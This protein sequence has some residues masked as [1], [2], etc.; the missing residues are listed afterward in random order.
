MNSL[1]A[2]I[3]TSASSTRLLTENPEKYIDRL[4]L[5]QFVFYRIAVIG[6][7]ISVGYNLKKK[8]WKS[9]IVHVVCYVLD[10]CYIVERNQT[11]CYIDGIVQMYCFIK[12]NYYLQFVKRFL[13]S[14]YRPQSR[15]QPHTSGI[16]PKNHRGHKIYLKQ[17]YTLHA[18]FLQIISETWSVCHMLKRTFRPIVKRKCNH[19]C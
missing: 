1:A 11:K 7:K 10:F 3:S 12:D 15:F 6:G 2:Y 14:K 5:I 4:I 13:K 9:Y 17:T 18:K 16:Y 19:N 8:C